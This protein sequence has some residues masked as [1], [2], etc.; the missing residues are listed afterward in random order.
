NE[1]IRLNFELEKLKT[2]MEQ[3]SRK[4]IMYEKLEKRSNVLTQIL[5]SQRD[6]H[7]R[8]GIGFKEESKGDESEKKKEIKT[9]STPNTSSARN[10]KVIKTIRQR[11]T[12]PRITY[13]M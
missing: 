1:C 2:E 4:L 12:T 11:T 5:C 3:M 7:D 8:S 9:T 10:N 6:S 13:A